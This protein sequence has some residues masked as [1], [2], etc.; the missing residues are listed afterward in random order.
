MKICFITDRYPTK[1][2]PVNTFLDKL[3]CEMTDQGAECTVVA[4]YRPLMDKINKRNY[5]TPFYRERTT[6]R[7]GIIKIYNPTYLS[8]TTRTI[9]GINMAKNGL[10]KFINCVDKVISK[11]KI[12]FDAIYGHFI[13]PSGFA[14]AEM[15]R[16][17]GKPSFFAYGESSFG[18]VGDSFTD[19]QVRERL[20]SISGVIAVS[21]KNRDELLAHGIVDPDKI[22]VFPNAIDKGIFRLIDK[23]SVREKL[24]IGHE[25]FVVAFVGHFINRKGSKRVSDALEQFDDVKSIFIGAGA[26]EPTCDNIIYK[27]RL[28]HDQVAE[29]LNAADVFVLPTLAEGCC[30]AI[31]EAMACGLPV[32]SSDLP[33]NDDILD[34]TNSIRIDPMDVKAIVCAINTLRENE[35]LRIKL[36]EGALQRAK[37]LTIESR[38]NNILQFMENQSR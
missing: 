23:V 19:V 38:A 30:N 3:I 1:D 8:A 18:I 22:R 25:D 16:K 32:V 11:Q 12:E 27:G 6:A 2:Y 24:G 31:V 34:E 28:P 4:P 33:F 29:Y 5:K 14:A 13:M 10:K 37:S 7:G 20:E 21:S 17:Y 36:S 15:G 35:Q 9:A 26:E